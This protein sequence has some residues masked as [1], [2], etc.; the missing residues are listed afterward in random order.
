MSTVS[1]LSIKIMDKPLTCG[2]KFALQVL[3]V[4]FYQ[5]CTLSMCLTWQTVKSDQDMY[6]I[7]NNANIGCTCLTKF[8]WLVHIG[9]PY[10]DTTVHTHRKYP[11]LSSPSGELA[12]IKVSVLCL[13]GRI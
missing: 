2:L 6:I 11:I 13:V 8:D 7:K 3:L 9:W 12:Y 4:P 10:I 1:T 5:E